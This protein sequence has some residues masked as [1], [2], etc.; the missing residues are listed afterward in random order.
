MVIARPMPLAAPVT[1]T[2]LFLATIHAPPLLAPSTP[3]R[4]GGAIE[5]W[6]VADLRSRGAPP[7]RYA[8]AIR[9]PSGDGDRLFRSAGERTCLDVEPLMVFAWWTSAGCGRGRGPLAGL[10]PW[11]PR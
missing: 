5:Q 1:M 10:A 7:C 8:V 2:A 6:F 3:R 9:R 4:S 11:E